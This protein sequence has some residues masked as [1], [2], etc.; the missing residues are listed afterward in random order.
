VARHRVIGV[1]FDHMHMGDLLREVAAHSDAEI[2]GIYDPNRVRMQA[3]IE[4]FSIPEDRAFTEFDR[5]LAI[6]KADLAIVCSA[7]AEHANTVEKIA[8]HG[9]HVMV[10]KP[11]AASVADA[12]RMIS[13]MERSGKRLAINWP[14][15]WVPSHVTSKRLIDEGRI[16]KL[17]EV[18]FYDGNR[19]PL[20]HLADKVEVSPAEVEVQKPGSWWYKKGAGGGSLLDYLGYGVTLGARFMGGAAPLEV[21]SVIDEASGIEVDQ[22]SITVARYERGLSKF[23]TRWGTFTDPWTEQPQ[24]KC[25]FVLVGSDGTISSYDYE[26]H[27]TI[28]TRKQPAHTRVP[29][30]TLPTGRRSAVEYMLARIEDGAPITGPLDPALSLVGQRIVDSAVLSSQTKRTVPLI[31]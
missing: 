1:S 20:Y 31:A 24:P 17:I 10:E 21:T 27:V 16:G 8:P 29:V 7:T 23:E 2:A 28:Q 18:H 3:A 11:F 9:L 6:A 26:D 25:G 13:A 5:C 12:R 30:D 19:G 14:L 22:H 4:K 15:A